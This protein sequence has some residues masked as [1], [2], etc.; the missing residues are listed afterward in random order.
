VQAPQ[1][2]YERSKDPNYLNS[3]EVGPRYLG[4]DR[5]EGVNYDSE[6]YNSEEYDS[7]GYEKQCET[8]VPPK[9]KKWWMIWE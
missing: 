9:P 7:V 5:Y 2:V 3:V 1:A 8:F 6:E 4:G